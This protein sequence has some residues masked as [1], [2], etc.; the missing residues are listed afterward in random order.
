[1]GQALN[2]RAGPLKR[3]RFFLIIDGRHY[4]AL[5]FLLL[6]YLPHTIPCIVDKTCGGYVEISLL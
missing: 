4:M 2:G 3:R 5:K 6:V 1:M